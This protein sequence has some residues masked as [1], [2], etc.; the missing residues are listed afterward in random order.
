[1]LLRGRL[2]PS[3]LLLAAA[4]GTSS[5]DL[6]PGLEKGTGP[7]PVRFA[8]GTE[9]AGIRF[10]HDNGRSEDLFYVESIP[11]GAIFFDA[12]QDGAVD[13]YLLNG[14]R[15][16]EPQ[17]V[18]SLDAFY[19]NDGTGRFTEATDGSGLGDPLFSVGVSGADYD[20]D[21]DED[22]YVTNF[23][24]PNALYQND[25]SARFQDAA[26]EALVVGGPAFDSSSAFADV[27]NDGWLDLFV[28]TYTDHSL[29]N[30]PTCAWPKRDGSGS[31]RRYCSVERF[32]PLPDLLYRN[33][34]DG[35]FEDVSASSGVSQSNGRTLGVAFADYDD[36]GDQDLFLA[37]DRGAN[38]YYENLGGLKLQEIGM[39]TG[40]ALS[41]DGK[42]QAGMGIASDDFDGDGRIDVAVTYFEGESNGFYKNLGGHRF[43]DVADAN[44]TSGPSYALLAWGIDFF[45]ADL[46]SDLD[47]LIANGHF[48]DNAHLFREPLAG[49]EQSKLFFLNDGEGSFASLGAAAG[50]AFETERVGRGLAT[51]DVDNDGDVDAL[52]ANLHD[53]PELLINHSPRDGKHWLLVHTIGT[54]S[55]RDGIGTRVIVHLGEKLLVEEVHSGQSIFSQCDLRAHFGLG[56]SAVVPLLEIRWPSGRVS[57]LENVA[58]DQILEV[59][60]PE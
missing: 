23:D 48:I 43:V 55:N 17:G 20:N 31:A 15:L 46:D 36:D 42:K 39:R 5:C 22:L 26:G 57:R 40:A 30:N 16:A 8:D 7:S 3:L 12:D 14:T 49:Y 2:A 25:G 54:K 4:S 29:S 6:G 38:R 44:G 37:S 50:P 45:D 59:V 35:T 60:E 51:A 13:L 32:Q 9:E 56:E 28:G 47:C 21:G 34:G 27:D 11:A 18:P 52:V 1:M 41:K 10:R 53:E 19:A 33:R 58:A 24:A